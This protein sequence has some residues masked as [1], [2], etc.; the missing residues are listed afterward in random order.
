MAGILD[1]VQSMYFEPPGKTMSRILCLEAKANGVMGKGN[2]I[3]S[4]IRKETSTWI[5]VQETVQGCKE[6]IIVIS[7]PKDN[8]NNG[9]DLGEISPAQDALFRAHGMIC[10]D[11]VDQD[12]PNNLITT[13]LVVPNGQV[14]CLM[15]KD[16]KII[17][18]MR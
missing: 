5:T 6:R 8:G 11:I 16:G 15:G 2:G 7:A 17:Q 14:G 1:P 13:H 9:G 10:E 4:R 3:V 18:Q 12:D